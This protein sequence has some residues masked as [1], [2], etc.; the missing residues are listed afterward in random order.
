[1]HVARELG[2]TALLAVAEIGNVVVFGGFLKHCACV[3]IAIKKCRGLLKAA[4]GMATY[5][6]S[7]TYWKLALM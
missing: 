2:W 7:V 5:M 3:V 6:L 1:V 4:D